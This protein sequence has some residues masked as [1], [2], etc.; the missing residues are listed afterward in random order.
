MTKRT[1]TA[2]WFPPNTPIETMY[3]HQMDWSEMMDRMHREY[4]RTVIGWVWL[5][6][7][8]AKKLTRSF[9]EHRLGGGIDI[10]RKP[11]LLTRHDIMPTELIGW[12]KPVERN[13]SQLG[14]TRKSLQENPLWDVWVRITP[15]ENPSITL[16]RR[17][18]QYIKD[19]TAADRFEAER[20]AQAERWAGMTQVER[21]LEDIHQ[22]PGWERDRML[23]EHDKQRREELIASRA[24]YRKAEAERPQR[25]AAERAAALRAHDERIEA[26]RRATEAARAAREAKS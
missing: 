12:T 4:Q 10:Y 16:Q 22:L 1:S 13:L 23:E 14:L 18:E 25:E 11:S 3:K 15:P 8:G 21:D 17:A 6:R 5:Q 19:K 24:A 20:V 2:Y 26:G 9:L 7:R